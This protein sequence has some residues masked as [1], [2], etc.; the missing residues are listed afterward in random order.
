MT[1][2]YVAICLK[3]P[4]NTAYTALVALR[5]LGIELGRIE[6]ATIVPAGE[7]GDATALERVRR[8]ERLFN[9]NLHRVEIRQGV[10]DRGELLV[11]ET[12]DVA[13]GG[14]DDG[15]VKTSWRL[16]DRDGRPVPNAT[17][18]RARDALLCNPAIEAA[19][20]PA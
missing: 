19:E 4:D 3:V 17:L 15:E 7:G 6:R 12:T 9:P 13:S 10:P 20:L 16:Y 14:R 5:R 2:R 11:A 1:R 8:N 18:E